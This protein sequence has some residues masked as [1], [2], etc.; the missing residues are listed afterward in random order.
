MFQTHQVD[1]I[2]ISDFALSVPIGQCQQNLQLVCIEFR[3]VRL[4]QVTQTV[5]AYETRTF[6]VIL[7]HTKSHACNATINFVSTQNYIYT[8]YIL[9]VCNVYISDGVKNS[10]TH[11]HR[12]TQFQFH[13]SMK[14]GVCKEATNS[15]LHPLPI[16]PHT[17]THCGS[18]LR[19]W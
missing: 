6:W 11:R 19:K 13:T 14:I 5:S 18:W 7:K 10:N 3:A 15:F 17:H 8:I 16:R 12:H 9:C 2:L 1:E 4:K